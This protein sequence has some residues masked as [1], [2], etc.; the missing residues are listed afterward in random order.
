MVDLIIPQPTKTVAIYHRITTA[1]GDIR[2][3]D[4]GKGGDEEE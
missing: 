1:H 4:K 2:G 3:E